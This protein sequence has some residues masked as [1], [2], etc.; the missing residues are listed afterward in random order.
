MPDSPDT[1]VAR[2]RA[3]AQRVADSHREDR[4]HRADQL[5]NRA[6]LDP[7]LKLYKASFGH[8]H[9]VRI[10]TGY[11]LLEN[12]RDFER[13]PDPARAPRLAAV[14]EGVLRETLQD[15]VDTRPPLTVLSRRGE[16]A[17]RLHLSALYVASNVGRAGQRFNAEIH[18]YSG[19]QSW[20]NLT[21]VPGHDPEN[22]RRRIVR[23]VRRLADLQLAYQADTK[24]AG[25]DRWGPLNETRNDQ[26]YL[27]PRPSESTLAIP[28]AFFQNGW[29]LVLRPAEI[30]TLLMFANLAQRHSAT[31][32]E[33]GVGAANTTRR[34]YYGVTPEVY[35]TH[36]EL[37]EFGFLDLQPG[38]VHAERRA[39]RVRAD[40]ATAHREGR[41]QMEALR[42]KV[43]WEAARNDA[44]KTVR[45][46]FLS[47]PVPP[48][49][50]EW[51]VP[52]T[53]QNSV[54][55]EG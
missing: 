48:R 15:D 14:N 23:A 47:H 42:F 33:R 28:A 2:R 12:G 49:L 46:A 29:H 6:R 5:A 53:A 37:R 50:T 20:A 10:R 45:R 21:A 40:I 38:S 1:T 30:V 19:A 8:L 35:E 43:V 4:A 41:S 44:A 13:D 51:S 26:R 11:L 9:D 3:W 52:R 16:L 55:M 22:R 34:R 39:G 31:H 17:L 7:A 36:N 24:S 27:V 32:L 18:N 25:W 54:D